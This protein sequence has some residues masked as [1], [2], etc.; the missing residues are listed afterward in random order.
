[1]TRQT[2][3][4]ARAAR[5]NGTS[6]DESPGGA[7]T[8][9][10]GRTSGST[11][12]PPSTAPS[13]PPPTPPSPTGSRRRVDL[14][15]EE[16]LAATVTQI[17]TVGLAQT[18][19]GDVAGALGVSPALVFYHFGTKDELLV[20]AFTYAVDQDLERIDRA[21]A[22]GR[23]ATERLR[24]MVRG[25]GPTGTAIGWRLW[26][27]GWAVAQRDAGIRTVLRRLDKRWRDTFTE[28][29]R[30][31]VADGS[32]T[33]PDPEATVVRIGALLDGLSVA[34]L[35]NRTVTRAQVRSW[36]A[37]ALADEL[38]LDADWAS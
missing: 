1:M 11:T 3:R 28:I 33:C 15:R 5:P 32:F 4:P 12:T 37:T 18:R 35:V 36:A 16:I 8:S 23:T 30:D 38:G 26:I 29:I 31:G 20:E 2:P 9:P 25:Y 19:V 21:A 24:A 7:G 14:R 17:A 27:D 6:D 13:T 22:R 10:V 34:S